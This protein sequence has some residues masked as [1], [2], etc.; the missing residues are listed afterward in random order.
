MRKG[1]GEG[2]R[3]EWMNERTNNISLVQT[4]GNNKYKSPDTDN[5]LVR[6][7]GSG[8]YH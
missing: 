7:L 3:D 1:R 5:V 8:Y 6:Y 4:I 2:K